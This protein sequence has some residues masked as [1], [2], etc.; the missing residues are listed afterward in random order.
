MFEEIIPPEKGPSTWLSRDLKKVL[1]LVCRGLGTG[2][3]GIA[4]LMFM[5]TR[6]N[7]FMLMALC[8]SALGVGGIL[9]VASEYFRD[10]DGT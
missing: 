1:V 10:E 6:F 3:C 8:I 5:V 4:V 7:D 9:L 2:L